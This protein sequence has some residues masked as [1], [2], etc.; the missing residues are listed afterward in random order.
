MCLQLF[1]ECRFIRTTQSDKYVA[2]L[3]QPCTQFH[4]VLDWPHP[5]RL[6]GARANSD[7]RVATTDSVLPQEG[8][9]K[10]FVIVVQPE[11]Q[12]VLSNRPTKKGEE[13]QAPFD[14]VS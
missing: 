5:L 3:L 8:V 6:T 11:F 4:K 13:A 1:A 7:D 2:R 9:R 14:F 10:L 12:L